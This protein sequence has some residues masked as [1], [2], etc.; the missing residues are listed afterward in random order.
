MVSVCGVQ[1][2]SMGCNSSF[3]VI[4]LCRITIFKRSFSL[5]YEERRWT[6][7]CWNLIYT[8]KNW[9]NWT[10]VEAFTD[11]DGFKVASSICLLVRSWA[12]KWTLSPAFIMLGTIWLQRPNCG[13]FQPATRR[14][15]SADHHWWFSFFTPTLHLSIPFSTYNT[16]CRSSSN[17]CVSCNRTWSNHRFR[18]S[19]LVGSYRTEVWKGETKRGGWCYR[20]RM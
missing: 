15:E 12:A 8:I 1:S 11:K 6:E 14:W 3:L 18:F 19:F 17:P 5:I 20:W 13:K 2:K 9:W 4:G 7:R 10:K 16:A